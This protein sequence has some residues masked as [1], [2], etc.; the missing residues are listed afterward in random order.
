[1][2]W[3]HI[4]LTAVLFLGLLAPALAGEAPDEEAVPAPEG[5][6]AGGEPAPGEAA[7]EGSPAEEPASEGAPNSE[8][9][10]GKAPEGVDLDLGEGGSAQLQYSDGTTVQIKEN[11]KAKVSREKKGGI[12]WSFLSF[13]EGVFQVE[14]QNGPLE[15]ILPGLKVLGVGARFQ[16]TI[17][18]GDKAVVELINQ[19]PNAVVATDVLSDMQ[20]KLSENQGITAT[21]DPAGTAT[22]F[23]TQAGNVGDVLT[24][25]GGEQTPVGPGQAFS[26][27]EGGGEGTFSAAE[28]ARI[29]VEP[30]TEM[31]EY[32]Y[33]VN[34]GIGG[35]AEFTFGDG[36]RAY[37][38]E[39]TS[40]T[41]SVVKK[42]EGPGRKSMVTL[43][44][45]EVRFDLGTGDFGLET[46]VASTTARAAVF[47]VEVAET[48]DKYS[49]LRGERILVRSKK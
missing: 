10:G 43:Q 23:Q 19:G 14:G 5:E 2:R 34:S 49:H 8:R 9:P 28:E 32:R 21:V 42:K 18:K 6:G 3:F 12:S 1:M 22:A 41:L 25:S 38:Q 15:Y 33:T 17:R 40:M 47:L 46:E 48:Y 11:S 36:G 20:I 7:G 26:G 24:E 39:A 35:K 30:P 29:D 44:A 45:G 4:V 31:V 37:V 13:E 16:V 27:K